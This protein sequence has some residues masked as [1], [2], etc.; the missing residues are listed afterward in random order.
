[1]STEHLN[2]TFLPLMPWIILFLIG[3]LSTHL[4]G[5]SDLPTDTPE[6]YSLHYSD[7]GTWIN[8]AIILLTFVIPRVFC[9]VFMTCYK[10]D[11]ST[12]ES[13]FW[14]KVV[15]YTAN[16]GN[17]SCNVTINIIRNVWWALVTTS[18]GTEYLYSD[19][20]YDFTGKGLGHNL[21]SCVPH[22]VVAMMW[23]VGRYIDSKTMKPQ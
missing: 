15:I 3:V 7:L 22:M 14:I 13:S 20:V 17:L 21:L 4:I 2:L 6:E 8:L 12:W 23:T 11:L 10:P 19:P 1:M 18:Y 5:Q 16:W 9:T